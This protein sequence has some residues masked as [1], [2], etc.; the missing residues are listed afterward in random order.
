MDDP[1]RQ[2]SVPL[3]AETVLWFEFLIDPTLLTSYLNRTGNGGPK[4]IELINQFLAKPHATHP[5]SVQSIPSTPPSPPPLASSSA[6]L[7]AAAASAT[8]AS[9]DATTD[10]ATAEAIEAFRQIGRKQLA[11][12]ILALKVAA[13]LRWDLTT[14]ERHLTLQKQVQLLGDLCTV[15][16]GKM[17]QLP[18]AGDGTVEAV[19]GSGNA[20]A[21]QFALTLYHRWVLRAQLLK[22]LPAR[23]AGKQGQ[24]AG[25]AA[26]AAAA[27]S[28]AA[29][30]AAAAG[31]GGPPG[32]QSPAQVAL[33]PGGQPIGGGG[34]VGGAGNP[35]QL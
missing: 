24:A 21:L 32:Q 8:A 28:A 15:T 16:A 6:A 27:A 14:L 3:A 23:L 13:H 35:S 9:A 31:V 1:L 30:A 20:A 18:I 5:V 33:G 12:K 2:K 34:G 25:L 7:V 26:A 22:E 17:V 19:A 4:P 29:A 11:Q 10:A